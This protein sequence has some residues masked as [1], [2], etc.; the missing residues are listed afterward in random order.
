MVFGADVLFQ[1]TNN[2]GINGTIGVFDS[3]KLKKLNLKKYEKEISYH[4]RHAFSGNVRFFC[5]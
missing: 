4:L 2:V 1:K 5:M 3:I